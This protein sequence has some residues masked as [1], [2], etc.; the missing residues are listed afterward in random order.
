VKIARLLALLTATLLVGD[1]QPAPDRRN[2]LIVVDGLRPDYV[3]AAVMPNLTALGKRGVVFTRH[4]AVYPTVTRV[5]ASSISTGAYPERHGLLGNSVFFPK[6]DPA[7]PLD[8]ADRNSL[9]KIAATET[10]LLTAQT[11]GE[12]LQQA[13]RT[14]LVV[15]SGSSGS[16]FLNNH[17]VAGGAIIHHQYVLPESVGEELKGIGTP[18]GVD[19]PGDI[20]DRYAVDA[21]LK[22]GIARV[23]PAVTV[24]WLSGLDSTAH[25][26]GIGDPAT[27]QILRHVDGQLKRIEDELKARN[28]FEHYNVWVTSDHGFSTYTGGIDL[29]AVVKPFAGTRADGSP[30]VVTAGGAIYVRDNDDKATRAIVGSLQQTAGVGAIFTREAQADSLDGGIPGTLSFAAAR[31]N[32]DRSAQILFS[33]DWTDAA[34]DHGMRGTS[35]SNGVA[36]HG[37]SSP[38]DI[39]NTLIAAGPD[40]KRGATFDIPSANVDF[41]PT[42]LKLLGIAIPE[43]V[44]GRPLEEAFQNGPTLPTPAVRKIE[45]TASTKDGS[46]RVTGTFSVV[47]TAGHSYRYLDGTK[48]VRKTGR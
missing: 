46:Y 25:T 13:G 37:S 47:S 19:A 10:Q 36:G 5:N 14:M 1:A 18:P 20:L 34:N 35:R 41:A 48:V 42:F 11:M 26:K 44:Q 33:P 27:V 38:W 4:H 31:W 22:V 21:L 30:R 15:S 3:T 43:S 6:V 24:L 40:L 39:H 8:T 9:L 2:L 12:S 45:H 29:E 32:H 17:T 7:A 28:L 23:D 16:A